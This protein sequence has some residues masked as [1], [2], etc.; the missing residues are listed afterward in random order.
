MK[1]NADGFEAVASTLCPRRLAARTMSIQRPD[2]ST[3]P[4]R[5]AMAPRK[6][7]EKRRGFPPNLYE[8]DGYFRW[9]H[10]GTRRE[11]GLGRDKAKAFK[12]AIAANMQV[13]GALPRVSLVDRINGVAST[14]YE[15]VDQFEKLLAKRKL[16]PNTRKTYE[17]VCRKI[18]AL[19][20][21]DAAFAGVTTRVIAKALADLEDAGK[22]RQAQ[23][24]RG[25]LKDCF[26][27]AIAEGWTKENPALVTRAIGVEI[28]R[29]RLTFEVFKQIYEREETPWAKN[30][31]ALAL[32]SAQARESCTAAQFQDFREGYWWNKRGKTGAKI[33]IPLD[34]RLDCFGMSL[35]DVVRQCRSTGVVSR[36]LIHQTQTYGNSPVGSQIWLDTISRH[37]GDAVRAL[38]IDWQDKEPPTFHEIR[39][40]SERLYS[41][42]G[43]VNTQELLGHKDPQTTA[44]Y[45]DARGAEWVKVKVTG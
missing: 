9:R 22:A 25:L 33:C 32:V 30:V 35:V 31:Y 13:L 43:G 27:C 1:L 10:P 37:F 42:Q 6:R 34:I 29:A 12:E 2:T 14:W 24:M 5:R 39:S 45:H 21:P 36:Y 4:S 28:K 11:Y 26:N 41:A 8:T 16:A 3:Q 19:A 15:W 38:E 40:L 20:E 7:S 18:R 44:L 23:Q 17:S